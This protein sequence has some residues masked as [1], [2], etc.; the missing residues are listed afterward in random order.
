MYFTVLNSL[1]SAGLCTKLATIPPHFVSELPYIYVITP[2]YARSVQKAELTRI[3]NTF[4]HIKNLHWIVVEDSDERT[5][6]TTHFLFHCGINYT[7]LHIRSIEHKRRGVEQRNIGLAWLRHNREPNVSRGV[8]YFA[9][10][11]NTYSI[12]IF[13]EMRYTKKVSIW[14]VG[15]TFEARYETPI[16]GPDNKVKSWHAWHSTERK[17]ATDMA[18]FAINLNLLLN[19]PH[20]W[21]DNT[22]R[23]GFLESSLLSQLVELNDLEPKADNC[24]KVLVWHTKT[25]T[26]VFSEDKTWNLEI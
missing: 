12:E 8:V 7:H 24:T 4:S 6:L 26:P 5:N 16:I 20:V 25:I 17:F 18:G 2:T 21:F 23:D 3:A 13:E 15:L 10:D 19:N 14:P 1:V 22:T 11:D 9:D